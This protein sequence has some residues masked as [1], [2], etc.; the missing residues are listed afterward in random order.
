ARAVAHAPRDAPRVQDRRAQSRLPPRARAPPSRAAPPPTD[1]PRAALPPAAPPAPACSARYDLFETLRDPSHTHAL[2]E[3]EFSAL[4]AAA[5]LP[6]T[7]SER[8]GLTL[9]L[10]TQL[11]ASFPAPGGADELRRLFRADLGVNALG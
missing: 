9:P 5:A 3:A 1:R 6:L 7:R 10:E 4:F 11:A 8:H 2:T